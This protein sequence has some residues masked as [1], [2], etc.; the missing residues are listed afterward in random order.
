MTQAYPGV[1]RPANLADLLQVLA[2]ESV[3]ASSK[4]GCSWPMAK[5]KRLYRA[6]TARFLK[7]NN[8]G[9]TLDNPESFDANY[10]LDEQ[11]L[12]APDRFGVE[13]PPL[14]KGL[15]Y[16]L[17][18]AKKEGRPFQLVKVKELETVDGVEGA[19]V[20]WWECSTQLSKK[21]D[22]VKDPYHCNA[23]CMDGCRKNAYDFRPH[24]DFHD[25]VA[26]GSWVWTKAF[27][28]SLWTKGAVRMLTSSDRVER[29]V[30]KRGMHEKVRHQVCRMRAAQ[31]EEDSD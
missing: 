28:K 2:L 25:E 12:E 17:R 18:C 15:W 4:V 14:K 26:M 11:L 13:L 21:V 8:D 3:P 6:A 10:G 9:V 1:I 16:I 29:W 5:L 23:A 30:L 24:T 22:W 7:C 27:K 19:R 31:E 20:Q